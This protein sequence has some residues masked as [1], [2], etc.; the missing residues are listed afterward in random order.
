MH[1]LLVHSFLLSVD[2]KNSGDWIECVDLQNLPLPKGWATNAYVGITATTGQLSDN[3]D[4]LSFVTYS[5]SDVMDYE[6]SKLDTKTVFAVNPQAGIEERI[7]RYINIYIC[8]Y[9][10]CIYIFM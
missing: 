3:H 10:H 2:A 6:E 9:I 7:K 4:V 8:I 5:D 1:R